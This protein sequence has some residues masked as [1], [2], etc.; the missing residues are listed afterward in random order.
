MARYDDIPQ[1]ATRQSGVFTAQQART[2][3]WSDR[4]I[5]RRLHA[6]AWTR[7]A[8]T[9]LARAGPL[10]TLQYA[11]AAGL[12]WPESVVSHGTAGVLHGFPLRETPGA[13]VIVRRGRAPRRLLRVHVV[14]LTRVETT[15]RAGVL[16]TDVT[17]TAIDCL[18]TLPLPE[19]FDLWAW[20]STRRL[21]HPD[22]IAA[23]VATRFWWHGTPQ[24]RRILETVRDGAVNGAEYQFHE[25]LRE[26]GIDG[27][28][29]GVRVS[30]ESGLIGVV[31]VLFEEA[32]IVIEIDGFRAHSSARAFVTDRQRQN[33]LSVAGYLVLRFTWQ[34]VSLRPAAVLT[35]I[36]K[37]LTDRG[38]YQAS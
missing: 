9:G 20:L 33:R 22:D 2:E 30:D 14:P 12:T 8:G 10:S 11:V 3:G 25:L 6:G 21:A 28:A 17:R 5:R 32:M 19:A 26:H 18:A 13:D 35:T 24:L 34:E 23:A 38:F 15:L 4:Q 37:A 31:D 36:R 16:V 7:V 1:A 29:A 27:W